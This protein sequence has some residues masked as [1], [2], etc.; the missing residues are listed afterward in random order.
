MDPCLPHVDIHTGGD[1]DDDDHER[2]RAHN[3]TGDDKV[4]MDG[5]CWRGVSPADSLPGQEG[6]HDKIDKSESD[7]LKS[8]HFCE[9]YSENRRDSVRNP[10][11]FWTLCQLV[12]VLV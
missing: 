10:I 4:G 6:R 1:Q 3:A 8:C 5:A 12:S 9:A 11:Y 7:L 2:E